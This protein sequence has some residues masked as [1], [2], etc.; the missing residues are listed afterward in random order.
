VLL[1]LKALR[2]PLRWSLCVVLVIAALGCPSGDPAD[3]A[4]PDT[5]RETVAGVPPQ[6]WYRRARAVDLT[7]DGQADSVR[8]EA[9]GP[10]AD[11]LRI[12]LS[13]FVE[14]EEKHQERWGSSYE[15]ALLDS[16]AR[17]DPGVDVV[18]RAKLDSVLAS[19][20]VQRLD[21]PGV[22]LMAEDTAVLARLDPRPTHRVSFSYGYE[23]TTRL[24]WDAPRK[25]FVRLWSCC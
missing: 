16:S 7:G 23:T 11:S 3:E 12:T 25:Q 22:R 21:A 10:R 5:T 6:P 18:L 14:G 19:V 1:K 20:V 13:F 2:L 9:L 4:T 15:L 8:L 24:V 17:I